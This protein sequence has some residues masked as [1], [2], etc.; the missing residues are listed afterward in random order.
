MVNLDSTWKYRLSELANYRT[1]H[2]I[3]NCE[4]IDKPEARRK[5]IADD[6][7]LKSKNWKRRLKFLSAWE[8]TETK[9]STMMLCVLTEV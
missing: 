8:P 6:H 3:Q 4:I 7:L 9:A 1:I 2:N 5:A